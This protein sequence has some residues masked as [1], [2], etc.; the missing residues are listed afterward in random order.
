MSN[1][2]STT[3]IKTVQMKDYIKEYNSHLA[4]VVS[5]IYYV[6]FNEL[7]E[8]LD[9]FYKDAKWY[10]EKEK[11]SILFDLLDDALLYLK[12]DIWKNYNLSQP[13]ITCPASI[14]DGG[15]CD[16]YYTEKRCSDCPVKLEEANDFSISKETTE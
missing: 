4:E 2:L 1:D 5:P 6:L 9:I 11:G 10:N 7:S 12:L 16:D 13:T 8:E 15:E 3:T 14:V